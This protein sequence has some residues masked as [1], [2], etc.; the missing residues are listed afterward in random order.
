MGLDT[1]EEKRGRLLD[2]P[3]IAAV[4]D[5]A[6]LEQAL[7]SECEVVF[8]LFGTIVSVSS[9]VERVRR[10][11]K[12]A[13]V[14]IDLVEGLASREV[15][16]D[17]LQALCTPDGIISTRPALI[18]RARHLGLLT[19]QRAFILDSLSLDNLPAQLNVGKPDFIEILPGIMPRVIGELA[20]K[21]RTPI[22]AGGLVKYKD[23]VMAAIRAGAAAV[24][25][26]SPSV[27][28]M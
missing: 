17:A 4:K 26:S 8:L 10:S 1:L 13:I 9:L 25:T 19:V 22:I 16:V 20:Q 6:G 21:T 14:H 7:R 2:C 24:S 23:E 15:A 27:W 12:L 28:E 5:E 3:V 18:R 11:G